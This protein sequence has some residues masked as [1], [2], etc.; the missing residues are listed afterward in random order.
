MRTGRFMD[1]QSIS[2]SVRS[3][4]S[5][6]RKVKKMKKLL[7]FMIITLGLGLSSCKKESPD[8]GYFAGIAAKG[9]YDL[10]LEGK[11]KEYVAG[12]NMPNRIS[13]GYHEQLLMNAQM[14]VEQQNEEHQG[15][16]KVDI[17]SAKADTA[18]HVA[19]VFLAF[20]YG[21]STKE[22]IVVPMVQIKNEWKM[23]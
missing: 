3:K 12:F 1:V 5:R 4:F 20:T 17:I 16:K 14:F 15:L 7:F 23:R 13:E 19:D 9:Y 2:S 22:Q 10:L 6:I 18:H 11:Y 21:D 8:P